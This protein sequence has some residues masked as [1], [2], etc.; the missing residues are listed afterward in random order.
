MPP[1]FLEENLPNNTR[2][3]E[4]EDNIPSGDCPNIILSPKWKKNNKINE[5][6]EFVGNANLPDHILNIVKP[7]PLKFFRLF[8]PE[9]LSQILCFQTNL[10]ATQKGDYFKPTDTS[11]LDVFV[12]LNL[13]MGIKRL[14]SYKDF[15]SSAPDLHDHYT[16]SYMSEN[17]FSWFLSN[18]H[19]NDNTIMP[20]RN[21]R[22]YDK[23]YKL[24]PIC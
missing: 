22:D 17:R 19:I 5:P 2:N 7:T 20:P 9:E 14:P 4:E 8:W 15:W 24:R 10:Y 23:L 13:I 6:E 11:E 3:L 12:A 18:I 1:S 16:S 21:S